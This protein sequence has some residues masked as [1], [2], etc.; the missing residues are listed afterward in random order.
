MPI[1]YFSHDFN[2]YNFFDNPYDLLKETHRSEDC[3]VYEG[4]TTKE[5]I[6][7]EDDDYR[8]VNV[9]DYLRKKDTDKEIQ[10][11]LAENTALKEEVLHNA[12]KGES[13]DSQISGELFQMF[14]QE[15]ATCDIP[16][17]VG[18]LMKKNETL[19]ADLVIKKE[20][21]KIMSEEKDTF[22]LELNKLKKE[23][24]EMSGKWKIASDDAERLAK[25]GKILCLENT[26]LK[27]DKICRIILFKELK[28]K[29]E[30][31]RDQ[32]K[33]AVAII[34]DSLDEEDED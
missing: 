16:D 5:K 18:K 9:L 23:I 4:D 17:E 14:D 8:E 33:T 7:E 28:E 12:Q 22:V 6:E 25:G 10:E 27:E 11:L 1:F 26:A 3:Y 29:N 31:L 24:Q 32:V 15:V 30:M 13:I 21:I 2:N 34:V 20:V 19:K